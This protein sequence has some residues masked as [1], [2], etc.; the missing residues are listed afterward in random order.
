MSQL[1][2]FIHMAYGVKSEHLKPVI[3]NSL[4]E[5]LLNEAKKIIKPKCCYDN[6]YKLASEWNIT[7]VIG[8]GVVEGFPI[9]HA[10][11]K[12][13]DSYF[14]PTLEAT[15]TNFIPA[16]EYYMID[17]FDGDTTELIDFICEVDE[18]SGIGLYPPMIENLGYHSKWNGK[19]DTV[20][21]TLLD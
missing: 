18:K 20:S 2:K 16:S 11:I 7:Y 17:E 14:D 3:I 15:Q 5:Y 13:G 9:H 10:W 8:F 19:L 21:L 4:P 12:I 6:C 1:T